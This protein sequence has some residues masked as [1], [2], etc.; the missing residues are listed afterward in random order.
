VATADASP[1]EVEA[2]TVDAMME[3]L[4]VCTARTP[5]FTSSFITNT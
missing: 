2:K 5:Y 4:V 1:I 3:F